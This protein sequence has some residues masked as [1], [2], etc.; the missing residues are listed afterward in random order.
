VVVLSWYVDVQEPFDD[1]DIRLRWI[2]FFGKNVDGIYV[3]LVI[4]LAEMPGMIAKND[5]AVSC[6]LRIVVT[7]GS[8]GH[9]IKK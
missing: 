9:S 3:R 2:N 7:S 1:R 5:Q 6:R 4:P 8:R